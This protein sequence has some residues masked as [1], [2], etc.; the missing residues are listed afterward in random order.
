MSHRAQ[1][2]IGQ[3]ITLSGHPATVTDW[4]KHHPL[5]QGNSEQFGPIT[6]ESDHDGW[7][8]VCIVGDSAGKWWRYGVCLLYTSP[9]PRD[10][11]LSRMPSSA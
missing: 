8:K 5:S 4:A 10:G 2:L 7:L 9:S 11:L 3:H 1:S 6:M